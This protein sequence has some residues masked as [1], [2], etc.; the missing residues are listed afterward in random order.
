[1]PGERVKRALRIQKLLLM[2]MQCDKGLASI[3]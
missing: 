2:E 1:M 3:H